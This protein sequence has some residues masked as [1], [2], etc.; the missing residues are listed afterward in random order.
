MV[1]G[2]D[3]SNDPHLEQIVHTLAP[4]GEPLDHRQHQP[5]I[6]AD[7]GVP[8]LLVPGL[9][10]AQQVHFLFLS[11]HFQLRGVD[12]ADFY[13]TVLHMRPPFY[14]MY[15]TLIDSMDRWVQ[16]YQAMQ[17]FLWRVIGL[18]YHVGVAPIPKK[19]YILTDLP[20]L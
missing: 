10:L 12:P 20:P 7:Q 5:Q 6:A 16:K 1:N 18:Q 13:F 9:G 17:D 2:F 14:D 3:Q 19:T 4:S 8:G 15:N 11:Q